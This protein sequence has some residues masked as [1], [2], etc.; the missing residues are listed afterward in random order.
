MNLINNVDVAVLVGYLV[1][2]VFVGWVSGRKKSE[3]SAESF[4][5]TNSTLPWYAIG[6]SIIA[7]GISSEQFIGTVGF[8]YQ[9]GLPV[10]NWEWLNGPAILLLT[11]V[12]IPV[13]FRWK[14]VTMPQYLEARFNPKVR[15]L[16]AIITL[17]TYIFINLAGVIFSGA[18]A[19]N[20]ILGIDLYAGIWLLTIL[21]GLLVTYGGME[22]V[23]WTNVFQAALLL[24]AGLVVFVVGWIKIPGGIAGIL[25]TG[26]RAHLIASADHPAIPSS[27]LFILTFS[28]NVWFFCT[29]QTINQAALGARSLRHAKLGILFAGL[30]SLLIAFGDVFPGLIAF[31]IN[32]NLPVADA[33]FPYVVGELMPSG[34][35]GL[36]FAGLLGA[37]LS[38]IESLGNAAATIFT[39]DLYKPRHAGVPEKKLI[40]VGR[41]AAVLMLTVGALWAPVVM[42]FGHI[43]AYFQE[44]WAFIAIPVVVIFVLG[45]LWPRMSDKA[46]MLTLVL[47]FPMLLFP[48]LLR[49]TDASWNVYN[50]AGIVFILTFLFAVAVSLSGQRKTST[51]TFHEAASKVTTASEGSL[52]QS[53][54]FWAVLLVLL[55]I[56]VYVYFW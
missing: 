43:F 2:L 9:Y 4:F 49:I 5:L 7:G 42:R 50:V 48:Y 11:F 36:V 29:N 33:A 37:I 21:A 39:L 10:A 52:F 51:L 47:S 55:Y 46:A 53:E 3:A 20:S 40:S 6:F 1:V 30:L 12:F 14:I 35:R 31:A 13:Y 18:F 23:A 25:G 22:S 17:L 19:M 32:P 45:V 34:I 8:A 27:S 41:I 28:T 56:T 26:E 44:C 24:S 16:F 54:V 38:T 15:R